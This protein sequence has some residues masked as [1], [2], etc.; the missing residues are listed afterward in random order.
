MKTPFVWLGS[1]R[2]RKWAVAEKGLRLDQAAG[3][4]LP[5]P[6]GA[7][8]LNEFFQLVLVEGV[9]VPEDGRFT[10]PD[11]TWLS[12]T[13]YHGAHFPRLDKPVAVRAAFAAVEP[14][15][16]KPTAK[17]AAQLAIDFH[18]PVQLAH[19]LCH[20][21]SSASGANWRRDVLIMQMVGR[22]KAGVAVVHTG[23]ADADVDAVQVKTGAD[24]RQTTMRLPQLRRWAR[25]TAE[26]PAYAQRLQ[27]LLRGARRTFGAGE[28]AFDWADDGCICWLLQAR[29]ISG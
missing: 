25:P 12:D 14:G 7:I 9:I 4:G 5:V 29:K 13:L 21:W 6:P 3:A 28:W 18:D 19:S 15:E 23:D 1:G 17:S 11:P 8:L 22:E 26:L 10:A 24:E 27:R 20:L 16:T 2:A